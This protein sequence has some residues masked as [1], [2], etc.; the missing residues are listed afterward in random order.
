LNHIEARTEQAGTLEYQI[1]LPTLDEPYP[2]ARIRS[3]PLKKCLTLETQVN[4]V[5][6]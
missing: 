6:D 5:R 3:F 2:F 1:K 4:R